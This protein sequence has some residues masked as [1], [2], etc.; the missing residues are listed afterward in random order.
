MKRMTTV[1]ARTCAAMIVAL[2]CGAQAQTPAPIAI[3]LAGLRTIQFLPVQYAY[4]QGYFKREGLEVNLISLNSG[5]AVISGVASGSAQ[6]G[7]ASPVPIVFARAQN[8]PVRIFNALTMGSPK[9]DVQWNWLVAS[10]KSGI[11][12]IKDFAGKTIALNTMGGACELQFRENMA[13]AGV[14][15]DSAKRIVVPYPQMQAALQL[16][17]ADAACVVEPFRTSIRVSPEIKGN[18]LSNG[19]LADRSKPYPEDILFVREDWGNAN[20]EALR[21]LNR[22]VAA[23]LSDFK[24]DP[25]LLRRVM[26][27]EFKMSGAVV[28]LMSSGME[29]NTAAPSAADMK[30]IVDALVRH[31][32]LKTAVNPDDVILQVK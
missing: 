30:P 8:Q 14:P 9:G 24:K 28:S 4:K 19:T 32:M 23:A 15:F 20:M 10:E 22:G 26:T 17:N 18:S 6:V 12:S 11:K 2:S 5:P 31:Q 13:K 27:E 25:G 1:V 3:T 7:Y 16:G 21:R 29:F